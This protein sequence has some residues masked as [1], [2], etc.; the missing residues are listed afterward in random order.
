MD[1]DTKFKLQVQLWWISTYAT[2][3]RFLMDNPIL[4]KQGIDMIQ[5]NLDSVRKMLEVT[6][7]E[8]LLN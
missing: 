7:E 4:L 1:E 3:M 6:R 2:N 8:A 5:S